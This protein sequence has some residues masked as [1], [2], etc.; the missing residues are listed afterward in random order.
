MGEGKRMTLRDG[1]GRI[2]KETGGRDGEREGRR[3]QGRGKREDGLG[4]RG[5]E[6]NG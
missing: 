1:K 2:V 4:E 6:D 3:L 5:G